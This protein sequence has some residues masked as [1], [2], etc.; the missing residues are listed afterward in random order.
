MREGSGRLR[1]TRHQRTALPSIS[2]PDCPRR[3]RE[4]LAGPGLCPSGLCLLGSLAT[5]KYLVVDEARIEM[6]GAALERV[7][8]SSLT[9]DLSFVDAPRAV[10][11]AALVAAQCPDGQPG[12][13]TPMPAFPAGLRG[14]ALHALDRLVT[15]PPGWP[16]LKGRWR[17]MAPHRQRPSPGPRSAADRNALRDVTAR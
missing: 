11:A 13:A 5:P 7:A 17:G 10:A 6:V 2:W 4:V 16:Q 1:S 3:S 12:P 15:V 9:D 8:M 14:L